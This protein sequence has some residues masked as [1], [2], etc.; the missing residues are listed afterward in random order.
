MQR[1]KDMTLEGAAGRGFDPASAGISTTEVEGF[2]EQAHRKVGASGSTFC[3]VLFGPATA[4]PH[5]V[6]ERAGPESR[7]TWC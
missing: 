5:G 3:I 4:F 7:A 1:A 6:G 2:I